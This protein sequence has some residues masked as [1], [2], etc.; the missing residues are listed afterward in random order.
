DRRRRRPARRRARQVLRRLPRLIGRFGRVPRGPAHLRHRPQRR[1]QEHLFQP[2]HR[3][4]PTQRRTNPVRWPRHHRPAAAPLRAPGD[5]Q[6]LPDHR[7]LPAPERGGK[8]PRRG[9][10]AGQPSGLLV[11]PGAA[12]R[13]G[14]TERGAAGA[15]RPVPPRPAR[16]GRTGARRAARAGGGYGPGRRPRPAAA[17]RAD[18][19]HEPG[20]DARLHGPRPRPG[21]RT[22]GGAGGAQDEAGHGH[23]RPRAGAP[24]RRTAGRRHP[25]RNPRRRAG[26]ARVPG[27]ARL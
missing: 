22:D 2:A 26:A 6:V 19:R 20:G 3:R 21:R 27:A 4:L 8:R 9:P 10:S 25:G 15:R 17:G 16:R 14:G 12:A 24:P 18:R 23:L 1:G 13:A 7:R 11:A 5:S